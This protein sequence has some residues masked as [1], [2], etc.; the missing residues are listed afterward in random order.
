[1]LRSN[2]AD[3]LARITTSCQNENGFL[4][5]DARSVSPHVKKERITSTLVPSYRS[6]HFWVLSSPV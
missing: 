4:P 2:K 6:G 3:S 1:M 5:T